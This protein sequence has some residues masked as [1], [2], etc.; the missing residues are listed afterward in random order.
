MPVL[1]T[2]KFGEDPIKNDWEKWRHYFPHY[3]LMEAFSC[4]DNQFWSNLPQNLMQ[5]FPH[6][7]DATHKILLRLANWS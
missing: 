4:H 5:P 6:P 2:C 3:K 1:D 7:I